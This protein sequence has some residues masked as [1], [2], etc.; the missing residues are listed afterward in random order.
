MKLK[1]NMTLKLIKIRLKVNKNNKKILK[2]RV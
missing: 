2:Y 1:R